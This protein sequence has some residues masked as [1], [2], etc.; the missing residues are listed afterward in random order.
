MRSSTARGR[1]PRL[2]GPA[3]PGGCAAQRERVPLAPVSYRR[4]ALS[5]V[6][7]LQRRWGIVWGAGAVLIGYLAGN[8]YAVVERT[9]GRGLAIAGAAVVVVALV[10]WRIRRHRSDTRTPEAAPGD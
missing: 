5:E 2:E 7:R 4:D 6:P 1:A 3:R 9:V 8:S 10:V